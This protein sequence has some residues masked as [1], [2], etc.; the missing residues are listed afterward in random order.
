MDG[1]P[2]EHFLDIL[3]VKEVDAASITKSLTSFIGQK[4]LD[5]RRLVG[6]GYDGAATFS[7]CTSGVQRW[8]RTHS[9]HAMYVHTLFMPLTSAGIYSICRDR[10][11]NQQNIWHDQSVEIVFLF[12]KES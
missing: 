5:Y 11:Y 12:A 7:G 10:R 2:E 1:Y 8:L 6:Q 9:A 3:H 4:N